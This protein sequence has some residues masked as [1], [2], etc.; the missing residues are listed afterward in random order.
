M[1]RPAVGTMNLIDAQFFSP[2]MNNV[3]GKTRLLNELVAL[4]AL[5]VEA[6]SRAAHTTSDKAFERIINEVRELRS[7][8]AAVQAQIDALPESGNVGYP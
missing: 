7:K 5:I 8:R 3:H 4:D 6:T 2:P 1:L